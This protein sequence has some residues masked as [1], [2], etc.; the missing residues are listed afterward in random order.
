MSKNASQLKRFP[1]QKVQSEFIAFKGGW[2]DETPPLFIS[3]GVCREVQNYEC[4]LN[5][6]YS[7]V[8][9]YERH[10]GRTAPSS[11]NYAIVNVTITGAFATDDTI[12]GVTS[13]AT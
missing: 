6:G 9:G 8:M 5:G 3:P 12:T 11:A 1:V 2:D 4:S 13:G 10:D 7:R